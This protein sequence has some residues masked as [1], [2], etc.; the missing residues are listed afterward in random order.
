MADS[1]SPYRRTGG[2]SWEELLDQVNE[3]LEN[4]PEGS[5]CDP[6]SPID[7]PDECHRW[8]KSDIREVHDKLDEMPEDC[9][10][11]EDI[12]DLWKVSIIEDIEDQLG[13][14][15][16]D[17]EDEEVCCEPCT[18]AGDQFEQ[19]LGGEQCCAGC[20]TPCTDNFCSSPACQGNT[21][22]GQN[23]CSIVTPYFQWMSSKAIVC[24]LPVEIEELQEEID[25]LCDDIDELDQEIAD[26]NADRAQ[27]PPGEAGN[28][29][30]ASI[31]ARIQDKEDEKAE[32]EE[33]KEELEEEKQEKEEELSETQ[34][35]LSQQESDWRSCSDFNNN[36]ASNCCGG[37]CGTCLVDSL[38]STNPA[39]DP[40]CECQDYIDDKFECQACFRCDTSWSMQERFN[41]NSWRTIYS[42]RYA[43]DGSMVFFSLRSIYCECVN[44]TGCCCTKFSM[45]ASGPCSDCD[46]VSGGRCP[47]GGGS[48]QEWRLVVT[49]PY[50]F[51]PFDSQDG[52]PCDGER[53]SPGGFG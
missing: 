20:E 13:E 24:R 6:I 9:F 18:N 41:G 51:D 16:C 53:G 36:C 2:N 33:E 12:P 46:P 35:E 39:G 25:K 28:A 1:N 21:C 49:P 30:R 3:E 43:Y 11:F 37:T 38:P 47:S 27:C 32:I 40:E 22:R 52:T 50:D 23:A 45:G 17:C 48:F 10:D 8:S 19:F 29:C 5:S 7:T 42:G 34:A 31:D 44:T 14:A 26:L 15:W 4:P